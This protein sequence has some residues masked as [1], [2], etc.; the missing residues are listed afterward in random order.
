EKRF[1]EDLFFRLSMVEI[2][3][4]P[5]SERKEDLP[6][7]LRHFLDHFCG[8]YGKSIEGFSRRAEALLAR[9]GWPGNVRELE[10]VIGY[11]CMMAESDRIDVRDLPDNFQSD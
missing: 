6:L 3:L 5:L 2:K 1:R 7:L 10:N 4:P 11:A 9:Y 8:L